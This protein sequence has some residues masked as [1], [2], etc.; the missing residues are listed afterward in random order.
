[1]VQIRKGNVTI[2]YHQGKDS[3]SEV[4]A[5]RLL[6]RLKVRVPGARK[7]PAGCFLMKAH[8]SSFQF[9]KAPVYR[10][11]SCICLRCQLLDAAAW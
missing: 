9:N 5:D 11:A 4:T 3:I 1:M 2:D 7:P 10:G 6:N 8:N